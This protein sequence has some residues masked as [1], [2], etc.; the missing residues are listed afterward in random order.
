MLT[1]IRDYATDSLKEVKGVSVRVI[2]I[3]NIIYLDILL[4]TKP[5]LDEGTLIG[6][7]IN[8]INAAILEKGTYELKHKVFVKDS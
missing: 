1:K 3:E 6:Q 4:D 5:T 8:S 7:T 2:Q